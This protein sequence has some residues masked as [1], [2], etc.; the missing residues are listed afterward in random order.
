MIKKFVEISG[1]GRF[2]NYQHN[3]PPVG[4]RTSEFE[5][6]N[7][8][9]G[10]NGS[11]KTTLSLILQSLKGNNTLLTKKRA[12]DRTVAQTVKVLTAG[13]TNVLHTYQNDI[14]DTHKPNIE[15]F[16]IHFVNE[17]NYTGLEIQSTHRK[18]LL[19]IIFGQQGVELKNEI[20]II[21]DKIKNS[22]NLIR[23][24]TDK[25]ELAIAKAFT[26][27]AYSNITQD[28]DIDSKI[29]AK[30]AEIL[31][32]RS[33]DIIRGKASPSNSP[34][35]QLPFDCTSISA[36]LSKSINTISEAYLQKFQVHKDHIGMS[37]K[38]EEWLK[39]GYN[40]IQENACPFCTRPFDESVEILEAYHQYFNEE[41]NALLE[42]LS[43][44]NV[45]LTSFN[46]EAKLLE[47]EAKIASN[48]SLMEFW[49]TH[50]TGQPA[51][52]SANSYKK[53]VIDAFEKV[54][55][56]FESKSKNPIQAIEVSEIDSFQSLVS[57][58]NKIIEEYNSELSTLVA[59]I[60]ILKNSSN[61]NIAQLE[62]EL[63]KL[64]AI[65]KRTDADIIVM[66]ATLL[67]AISDNE[68]LNSQKEVKQQQ[69][70]AYS[71]SV[72]SS[73]SS[74]INQ[75]L[76]S[77]APYLEI[78]DLS[79][80]YVKSATEPTIQY[81]LHINGNKI[82]FTDNS[83]LP[84]FK[85]SLSEGDKSALALAFFLTKLEVDGCLQDKTIVFDDPVSSF[86]LHRK[87][88]TITKLLHFGAQVKQLFVLTH[89]IFFA[90]E[91]W[92]S[93]NR[94]NI[95]A[96]CCKIETLGDSACIVAY[97]IETETLS[98]I[99]KD[100][101]AIK[102]FIAN[103][104]PQEEAKR[105]IA[106]CLRPAL[107]SYLHLKF[108]D[109][110]ADDDWFGVLIGKIR[111]ATSTDPFYR[112]RNQYEELNEVNEYSKRYHHRFNPSHESEPVNDSELRT[113]CSKTLDLIQVI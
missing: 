81:A 39:Q 17:N 50:V 67:R 35:I 30:E 3:I 88:A 92:K 75:Y 54:K 61:P 13:T 73:Y 64:K 5:K 7:L 49:K 48:N 111:D 76:Q 15:V 66:C 29:F 89:N 24:N 112:L 71:T 113:F 40:S 107:E 95:N 42:Q 22:K 72:F 70:D 56:L 2:L 20:Q 108:F 36:L 78:K 86:D 33:F 25:I 47:I 46:L 8:I 34:L 85:Y 32:A 11:G 99:L 109:V 104:A 62:E 74:K 90:G 65:K 38:G 10:E 27:V 94:L 79:S 1:T 69:L 100:T 4:F 96:R 105:S 106:R 41:Y 23:E 110:V 16:D 80:A 82:E 63:K 93:L 6:I 52:F 26:A 83:T 68:A 37:G 57:N 45:V 91:F 87:T 98:S 77:F 97:N 43:A 101:L 84:S 28:L 12:F 21:K 55:I 18:N 58:L 19:E 102:K 51:L 59:T 103:G 44:L 14:W 53:E 9:Y 31:T 60:T